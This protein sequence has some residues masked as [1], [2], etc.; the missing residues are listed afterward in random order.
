[1]SDQLISAE[2]VHKGWFDVVKLRVKP[3]EGEEIEREIVRHP[4]GSAVLPYDPE[5]KV[6]LLITEAR[7]PVVFCGEP[8]M[9]EAIAGVNEDGSAEDCARR[10]ALEEGGLRLGTL[11]RVGKIWPTPSTSTERVDLFLAVYGAQDRVAPGGGL[12]EEEEH[13]RVKEVSLRELWR[14]VEAGSFRDAKTLVLLQ[15]LYIRKPELFR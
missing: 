14:E 5:R 15:A 13:V 3:F 1:M 6:A 4:S 2:T 12:E 7:P 10:E 8:R 9:P 11:E